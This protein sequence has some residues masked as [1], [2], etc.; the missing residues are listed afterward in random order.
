[1]DLTVLQQAEFAVTK[2]MKDYK[3]VV[4]LS[5]ALA[6]VRNQLAAI[7]DLEAAKARAEDMLSDTL[8]RGAAAL[9]A[10]EVAEARVADAKRGLDDIRRTIA[11][12]NQK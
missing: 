5:T 9:K 6:G 2:I 10:A 4:D 12:I 11:N 8:A 1:M 3:P 7:G